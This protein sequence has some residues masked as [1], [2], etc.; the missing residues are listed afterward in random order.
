MIHHSVFFFTVN[1]SHVHAIHVLFSQHSSQF[2]SQ[3]LSQRE[4]KI[5]QVLLLGACCKLLFPDN[6]IRCIIFE[7][8]YFT[9]RRENGCTPGIHRSP[10]TVRCLIGFIGSCTVCEGGESKNSL[11]FTAETVERYELKES[12]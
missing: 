7:K 11:L 2:S 4:E 5:V 3:F 10:P 1:V 9:A 8:K 12:H 6:Q